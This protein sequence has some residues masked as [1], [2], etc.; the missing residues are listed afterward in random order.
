M[1]KQNSVLISLL[2]VFSLLLTSGCFTLRSPEV[3]FISTLVKDEDGFTSIY[4]E[5]NTTHAV[6]MTVSNPSNQII[7]SELFYP[8]TVNTTFALASH[9]TIASAGSYEVHF[10][11]QDQQVVKERTFTF[12]GMQASISEIEPFWFASS[13]S[14]DLDLVGMSVLMYN[15]GDVPLYPHSFQVSIDTRSTQGICLPTVVEP[16]ATRIIHAALLLETVSEDMH[17]MNLTIFDN[18]QNIIGSIAEKIEVEENIEPI[19]Y[20]W[21]Y[22]GKKSITF[23]RL[24]WLNEYYSSLERLIVEDYS[25]YVFDPYDDIFMEYIAAL[26]QEALLSSMQTTQEGIANAVVSLAQ[27]MEYVEDLKDNQTCEYPKYPVETLWDQQGD[28]EDKAILTASILSILGVNTSLIRLPN[29]MAIGVNFSEQVLGQSYFFEDLYYLETSKE[30]WT[31]G[32]IPEEY[33]GI[34]NV[35]AYPINDRWF[36]NHDWKRALVLGSNDVSQRVKFDLIIDNEGPA[37][38]A[39]VEVVAGFLVQGDVLINQQIKTID[40][41]NGHSKE[42]VHFYL[43]VPSGLSSTLVS[44]V[45]V[46]DVVVDEKKAATIFENNADDSVF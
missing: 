2:L 40:I 15:S 41:F 19:T 38:L 42:L 14:N 27:L 31:V 20:S 6:N 35:T 9:W 33:Q 28:C 16:G 11:D 5:F 22:R 44:R 37:S 32:R 17:S 34:S 43:R 39:S 12:T 46:N 23:P 30:K 26:T 7:Y 24:E 29:H 10:V 13:D 45:V 1:L 21:E 36:F 3:S 8:G 4:L 25:V 18:Q